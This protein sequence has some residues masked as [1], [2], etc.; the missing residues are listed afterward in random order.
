[1]NLISQ[2]SSQSDCS[3][4]ALHSRGSSYE[5][6]C[7]LE[8]AEAGISHLR[9]SN[10]FGWAPNELNTV[11]EECRIANWDGLDA[12]PVSIA[13]YQVALQFLQALP[14]GTEAPSF[15]AEADGQLTMEW[16]RAQR[17]VLSISFSGQ[18]HLHYAALLGQRRAYGSEPFYGKVPKRIKELIDE[19]TSR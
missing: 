17:T 18:G 9:S 1:M 8:M 7:L 19:I 2:A 14:L 13:T 5:A 11:F 10:T 3:N 15:G 6:H 12:L 4:M 16:Y